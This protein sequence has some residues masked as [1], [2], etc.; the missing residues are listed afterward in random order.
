MR[1]PD[2]FVDFTLPNVVLVFSLS[3][4]IQGMY[5]SILV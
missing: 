4:K 2:L 3:L 5:I 1:K